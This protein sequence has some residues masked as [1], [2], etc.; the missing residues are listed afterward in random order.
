MAPPITIAVLAHNEERRIAA[1]LASL[2][3]GVP[4][5]VVVN[6]SR[7]RTAAIARGFDVTVHEWEQGGKARSWNRFVFEAGTGFSQA[8]IFIYGDAVIA[9]GSIEAL[10]AA[11]TPGINA[12]SA[13]PLNGRRAA[14][15]RGEMRRE[16][17]L[18]GDLYALSGDFLTRMKAANIR[19]P[20]DLI[21]DDGLIAALAKTD[22]GHERDW[23]DARVAV[24]EGAGFYCEPASLLRP[25]SWAAQYARMTNYSVRHFQN[26]LLSAI[27]RGP[28]PSALP[29]RL[30]PFYA[31]RR[32]RARPTQWWFDR[33]ALRRMARAAAGG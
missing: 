22:L 6:G 15:Y 27:L 4:V 14:A 18:F 13:L 30:A 5:H 21:G 9:P 11:L 25:R 19:L 1:C 17:G 29:E 26:H 33:R 20:N 32:F 28:G 31:E 16:H 3:H 23:D 12:A 7:D 2:P 8:H 24:V 10:A